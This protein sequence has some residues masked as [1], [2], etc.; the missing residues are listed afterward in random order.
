MSIHVMTM[1]EESRCAQGSFSDLHTGK[2][3][4][5]RLSHLNRS[6]L[7]TAAS[8]P[9]RYG[10]YVEPLAVGSCSGW[11]VFSYR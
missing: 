11:V 4:A 8:S 5:P 3:L 2:A 9:P 1:V 10:S 7:L 6:N